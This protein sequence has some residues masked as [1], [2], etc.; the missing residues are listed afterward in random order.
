[1][2]KSKLAET[3]RLIFLRGRP[4]IVGLVLFILAVAVAAPRYATG[5]VRV[6]ID[7]TPVTSFDNRDPSKVRFGNLEFRG[8]LALESKYPAFGGIS[9]IHVEPGGNRFIAVTD[10]GS[11][12]RGRIIYRDGR[13]AG[14]ADTEMAPI[15]GQDG[16]PLAARGWYDTE[17][18]A[19][20]DGILY[21]GIERVEQIVRFD[22]RRD[23][24]LARGQ[25]INV[26]ADFKTLTYNKS[27]ECV[28]APQQGSLAGELIAVSEKSLD[29]AGNLRSF[30]LG[31]NRVTRFSVKRTD[32]F[33]VSDCTILPPDDL[34]LLERRF[35]FVRGIAIRIRRVPISSLKEGVVVDGRTMIEADLAYEIDNMEGISIHRTTGGETIITIVSDDNFSVL[36][37]NLLLQFAVVG[38]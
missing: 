37:R 29:A 9:G 8:G 18:L 32:E 19:E 34:L 35:S 2:A 10:K 28:A 24:L 5:L 23:G 20:R 14:I 22:Y 33:D 1:V 38:E 7:A 21:V 26:P 16:R 4:L 15:L 31:A 6:V 13:P 25:P 11:W 30:V 17:S 12:L 3:R 27:L 36:Q